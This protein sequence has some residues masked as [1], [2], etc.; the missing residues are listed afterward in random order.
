MTSPIHLLDTVALLTDN[1]EYGLVRGQVGTVV[2]HLDNGVVEV[3]F[4]DDEGRRYAQIAV[5]APASLRLLH[6]AADGRC[7]FLSRLPHRAHLATKCSA[8]R[9]QTAVR[10]VD[11]PAYMAL[12][13]A[14]VNTII[15]ADYEGRAGHSSTAQ[16]VEL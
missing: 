16:S 8:A 10:R 4:C 9:R 6:A 7:N 13:D 1:R 5:A 12:W 3:E 2:E 15:H 11:T 14:L